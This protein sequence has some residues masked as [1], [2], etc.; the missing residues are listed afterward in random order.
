M[1]VLEIVSDKEFSFALCAEKETKADI[2][3]ETPSQRM[4]KV[5]KKKSPAR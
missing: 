1:V 4:N 3:D 2:V 5:K